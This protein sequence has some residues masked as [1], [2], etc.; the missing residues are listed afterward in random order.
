MWKATFS[1]HVE[2]MDLYSVNYIHWGAPKTWYCIPPQF[3][4]QLEQVAQKLFPDFASS[5]FNLL[6]HK[7]IMI[8]PKLLEAA[9]WT[10]FCTR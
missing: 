4:Y 7:A 10:T 9:S 6:R 2:D 3:G 5:C 1:W 8:G